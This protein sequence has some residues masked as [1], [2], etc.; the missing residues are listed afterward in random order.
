VTRLLSSL[1]AALG[2]AVVLGLGLAALERVRTVDDRTQEANVGVVL[3]GR[4]VHEPL[5][6]AI[7]DL[8]ARSRPEVVVLGN[9]IANTDFVVPA[10]AAETATDPRRI[11][12]LSVPNT[13]A[14]HW[15]AILKNRVYEIGRAHV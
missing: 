5:V 2:P 4:H 15:Y 13:M 12:K 8:L 10:W 6:D 11:A 1:L 7:D 14:A 3:N 9:S